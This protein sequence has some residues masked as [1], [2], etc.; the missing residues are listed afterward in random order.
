M[1][2]LAFGNDLVRGFLEDWEMGSLSGYVEGN[3]SS[4]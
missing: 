2:T 4:A 3:D 1:V